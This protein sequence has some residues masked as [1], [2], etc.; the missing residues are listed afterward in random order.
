LVNDSATSVNNVTASARNRSSANSIHHQLQ[1]VRGQ[2]AGKQRDNRLS[3]LTITELE[4][5]PKDK[6]VYEGVG[7]M[8]M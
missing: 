7:K 6:N 8:F 2:V 4:S 3:Q 5:F 1:V